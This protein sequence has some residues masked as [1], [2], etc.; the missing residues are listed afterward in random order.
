MSARGVIA[1]SEPHTAL[2]GARIL[3]RGGN[4]VDAIVAAKLAAT[5]TE[6][7]LTSL[8]GGGACIWGNA[9]KGYEV[10]DFF[11]TTPG[12]GLPAL[13]T[14]DFLPITVDF[15]QAAQVFHIGKAAA[16]VPGELVGLLHL[17]QRGGRLPLREVVAPAA[18]WA[19]N[20]FIVSP[21]ISMMAGLIAPILL[22]SPSVAALFC[23][24]G[25][26]AR[27]GERLANPRLGDFLHALGEGKADEQLDRYWTS[28]V[29]HFGP[30]QG[31]LIT[32]HDAASYAPVVRQPLS[33]P[34]GRYTVLTN[35]PPSAGGGLVGA[36]LRLAEDRALGQEEFL[37]AA[38]Q[39]AVATVL[40]D[41]SLIR[42]AGYDQRL[43]SD[44]ESIRNLVAGKINPSSGARQSPGANE[45]HLGATTHISVID[46]EGMAAAL[47]TS[48]GEGC[49]HALPELGIHV[50]NFLGE[51]DIN[52]AGFHRSP[53]GSW[54][55]T[56]MSPTIVVIDRG[57]CFALG[58]GGSNRIRS[59]ILQ[60]LLNLLA[61]GRPLDEAVNAPRMH[62]EGDKLWFEEAG[63]PAAAAKALDQRWPAATRF[64]A[65]SMFFGG[66]NCA[67][68]LDGRLA[69]AGDRRRGGV[70]VLAED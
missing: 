43:H 34:F 36:G 38:H 70:V 12:R 67:A 22:H 65:P 68:R 28:L 13:P 59:A 17:H 26:V 66:V 16:A 62:L 64:A 51:E 30:A 32:A 39:S 11:A 2:A 47:T 19:R 20:G 41:V 57:P 56:M 33:V 31:G 3:R 7:P 1:A 23:P 44:P 37:S 60:A 53:P 49:G 14:L 29:E 5:I 46:A 15:G 24:L 25:H 35:P 18:D 58:S 54:M 6:L 27:A 8:G 4:A 21:Q 45:N 48:N 55:S 42:R 9:A 69:G 63:L 10:V 40:A 50:N 61:Y 52:P